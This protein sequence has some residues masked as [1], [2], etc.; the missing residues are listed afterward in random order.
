LVAAV[1]IGAI[2]LASMVA[3]TGYAA[4]TLPPGA[5]VP[6]NAG[7]PEYSVWLSRWAGLTAWTGIGVVAY[8]AV[9]SLTVSGIT[10][11]WSPS[12][13]VVLLPCV[14]AVVLAAEA[15]AVISARR[16][17]GADEASAAVPEEPAVGTRAE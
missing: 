17:A 1:V 7:V 3:V 8:A 9:G 15:G 13:R 6:L 5:R 14:M 12:V 4:K 16:Q 10:A 11:T 2:F